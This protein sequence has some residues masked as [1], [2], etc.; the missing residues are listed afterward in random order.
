MVI[1]HCSNDELSRSINDS[2]QVDL[3]QFKMMSFRKQ[4]KQRRFKS[5]IKVNI[6]CKLTLFDKVN[7]YPVR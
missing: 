1:K 7:S 2:T 6:G 5:I 3:N 4:L